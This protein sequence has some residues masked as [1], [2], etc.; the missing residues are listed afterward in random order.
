MTVVIG[1]GNI[2]ETIYNA[3]NNFLCVRRGLLQS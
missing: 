3:P 2:L 1:W